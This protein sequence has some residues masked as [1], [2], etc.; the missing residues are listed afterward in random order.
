MLS[1]FNP[2]LII[3]NHLKDKQEYKGDRGESE[4]LKSAADNFTHR[5]RYLNQELLEFN[6]VFIKQTSEPG[7]EVQLTLPNSCL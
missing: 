1:L 7:A 6:A 4:N 3:S 5:E 2:I